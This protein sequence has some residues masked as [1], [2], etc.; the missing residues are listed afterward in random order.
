MAIEILLTGLCIL[1]VAGAGASLHCPKAEHHEA[2]MYVE[3]T[4]GTIWVPESKSFAWSV[5][6]DGVDML[7][8]ELGTVKNLIFLKGGNPLID[9]PITVDLDSLMK[10]ADLGYVFKSDP[11]K[12]TTLAI[13][14]GKLASAGPIS[15]DGDGI[16]D[17]YEIKE[18]GVIKEKTFDE[19]V[20]WTVEN[21]D[22]L[23]IEFKDGSSVMKAFTNAGI[24][25]AVISNDMGSVAGGGFR[26][27]F[28]HWDL[29]GA[30]LANCPFKNM[31][32]NAFT[33]P[34]RCVS[35]QATVKPVCNLLRAE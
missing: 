35:L 19:H 2:R 15:E 33:Q 26:P 8:F 28:G 21:A 24:L 10:A 22:Q 30:D 23:R 20:L 31:L 29:C 13:R 14:Q 32:Q 27:G 11:T 25:R 12:T 1:E 4:S 6:L 34:D 17:C 18:N 5:G 16:P 9:S 7:S 3:A